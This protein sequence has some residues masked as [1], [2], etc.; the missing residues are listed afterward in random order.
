MQS[1]MVTRLMMNGD[2]VFLRAGLFGETGPFLLSALTAASSIPS[3][4][5]ASLIFSVDP[6]LSFQSDDEPDHWSTDAKL[7]FKVGVVSVTVKQH[8]EGRLQD[9]QSMLDF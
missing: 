4:P 5:Q 2:E 7:K 9:S 6:S 1:V 8:T 3:K